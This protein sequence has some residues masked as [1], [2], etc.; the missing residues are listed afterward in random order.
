MKPFDPFATAWTDAIETLGM[1]AMPS[2][3][4]KVQYEVYGLHDAPT[5]SPEEKAELREG[6]DIDH[7]KDQGDTAVA[8]IQGE[9]IRRLEPLPKQPKQPSN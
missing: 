1:G 7:E 6:M 9:E 3:Q 8:L 4:Q 5:L 2:D